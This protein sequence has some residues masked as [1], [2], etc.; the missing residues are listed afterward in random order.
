MCGMAVRE[1][2]WFALSHGFFNWVVETDA[3]NVYRVVS[4]LLQR[5]M[6]ANVIDNI[7]DACAHLGS[8]SV[9]YGSG[10]R[11]SVAHF[12]ARLVLSSSCSRI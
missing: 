7:C 4:S 10:E 3:I 9:C 8:G 1:G 11:N 6:E 12:L 2:T 5:S